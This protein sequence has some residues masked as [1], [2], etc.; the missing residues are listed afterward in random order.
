MSFSYRISR[1]RSIL[2]SWS[3]ALELLF[4]DDVQCTALENEWESPPNPL[5]HPPCLCPKCKVD[6]LESEEIPGRLRAS[7]M[8]QR[9]PVE[10]LELGDEGKNIL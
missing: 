2:V 10:S 9:P 1:V 8:Q 7:G 6:P 5:M 3:A 4:V